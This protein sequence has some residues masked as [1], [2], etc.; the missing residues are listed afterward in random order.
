MFLLLQVVLKWVLADAGG[1]ELSS[2]GRKQGTSRFCAVH[3]VY[4]VPPGGE[5]VMLKWVPVYANGV[6]SMF[7]PKHHAWNCICATAGS[8]EGCFCHCRWC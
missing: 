8:A 6:Q 4:S 2:Q 1:A 7:L 3:I 5:Q